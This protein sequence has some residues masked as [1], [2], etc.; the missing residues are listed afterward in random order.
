L[1]SSGK[2]KTLHYI[3]T[4]A[5]YGSVGY[6]NHPGIPEEELEH[7]NTLYLGYAES[8]AVAEK[9]VQAAGD[10]GLPIKIY[11]LDDVIG[12]S[13]TGVWN[14][15]DFIF[16]YLK[17]CIQLGLAPQTNI[18]MNAVPVDYMVQIITHLS[19]KKKLVGT[20][21]NIFN[22]NA[23]EQQ[24]MFDYFENNGYNLKRIPF[25][26]WHDILVENVRQKNDNA[27]YPLIPLFTERYSESL[28][29]I[30][31][32]YAEG[33]RPV[34]SNVNTMRGLQD[35]GIQFPKLDGQLFQR[36]IHYFKSCG[37]LPD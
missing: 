37:Y 20:A 22:P 5:V 13:D 1:A 21:F 9:L 32:M 17:G 29:S 28:L 27:L 24:E 30:V 34:F 26:E 35:S 23:I 33:R 3:S 4:L 10:Q 8:K 14:T 7:I 16:R 31:E 18:R 12:H 2:V 36:Y 11:R 25:S 6:F 19:R 15:D